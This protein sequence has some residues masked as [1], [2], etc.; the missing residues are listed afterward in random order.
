MNS[1]T[2]TR[3]N[4]KQ[5]FT[6]ELAG[7]AKVLDPNWSAAGFLGSAKTF[8]GFYAWLA[9][10]GLIGIVNFVNEWGLTLLGLS[11]IL[12]LFVRWSAMLGVILMVLY[13]FAGNAFP[14]VPNGFIV[15]QHI[16]LVLMLV[17]FF[18]TGAG[19]YFG[20]DAK[21]NKNASQ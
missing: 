8:S 19:H 15:D 7:I 10:P 14:F 9:Q 21:F 2:K 13:Y 3:Q 12:G 6:I 16:I 4:C 5:S 11:L 17:F 18:V 1:E 20:L